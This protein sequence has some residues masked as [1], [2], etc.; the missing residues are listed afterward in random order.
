MYGENSASG[1]G[2]PARHREACARMLEALNRIDGG[3]CAILGECDA[4]LEYD[5]WGDIN[6]EDYL[7]SKFEYSD[8]G[9]IMRIADIGVN[10]VHLW[11]KQEDYASALAL[12]QKL[13]FLASGSVRACLKNGLWI[14]GNRRTRWNGSWT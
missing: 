12:G 10:L 4:E 13:V 8:P 2:T 14:S 1:Q 11:A 3:E 7:Q 6:W 5:E 9:D